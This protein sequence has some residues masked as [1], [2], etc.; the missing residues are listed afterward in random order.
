MQLHMLLCVISWDSIRNN[1]Q[2]LTLLLFWDPS[3]S[4]ASVPASTSAPS[5]GKKPILLGKRP[6]LGM[7]SMLNQM[8]NY[9]HSKQT[10]VANRLSVFQSPD[11]D[12]EEDYEQWLEIKGKL[13][14]A[15]L[16]PCWFLYAGSLRWAIEI[17]IENWA[18]WNTSSDFCWES[19]YGKELLPDAFPSKRSRSC[20]PVCCDS[21]VLSLVCAICT[22]KYKHHSWC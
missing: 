22:I 1:I 7:S 21:M 8:K 19:S 5:A 6:S 3:P 11:D 4:S 15:L 13:H 18:W 10:P 2:K 12:E 9:S 17:H 14:A 20:F 16:C